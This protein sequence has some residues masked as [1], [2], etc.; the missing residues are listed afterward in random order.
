MLGHYSTKERLHE[1]ETSLGKKFM[2]GIF[3]LS[4][5]ENYKKC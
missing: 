1:K 5:K 3:I 2:Y 4:L